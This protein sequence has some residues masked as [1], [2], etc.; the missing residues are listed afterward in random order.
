MKLGFNK[1]KKLT[2]QEF[3]KKDLKLGIK[4]EKVSKIGVFGHFLQNRSLKVPNL[5]HDNRGQ[6]SASFEYGGA[7]FWKNLNTN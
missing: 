5:S 1:V 3:R 2:W 4:G 7:I 6:Q